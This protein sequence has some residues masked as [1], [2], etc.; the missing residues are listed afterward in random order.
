MKNKVVVGVL[1]QVVWMVLLVVVQR[2]ELN[3]ELLANQL[4]QQPVPAKIVV[5]A[6]AQVVCATANRAS[7]ANPVL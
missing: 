1:A 7:A 6:G 5:R 2:D 3:F 4:T